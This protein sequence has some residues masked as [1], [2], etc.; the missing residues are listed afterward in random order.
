MINILTLLKNLKG[1]FLD[2]DED[3]VKT[4]IEEVPAAAEILRELASGMIDGAEASNKL[5]DAILA[6]DIKKYSKRYSSCF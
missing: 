1:N 5:N 3:G 2:L 6:Q 4:L